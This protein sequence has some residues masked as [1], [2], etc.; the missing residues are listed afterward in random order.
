[1]HEHIRRYLNHLRQLH[2]LGSL[3]EDVEFCEYCLYC[4]YIF[5]AQTEEEM[6][7]ER[8]RHRQECQDP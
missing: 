3:P 6:E 4:G 2:G 5:G 7:A 8:G 1:M